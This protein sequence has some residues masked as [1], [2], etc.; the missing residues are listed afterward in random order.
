MEISSE[1]NI[2]QA[3]LDDFEQV[4]VLLQELIQDPLN[5]RKNFFQNALTSE[6]YVGLVAEKDGEIIGFL[7]IWHFP[8]PGHGAVL[9]IIPSFIVSKNYRKMGIGDRLL[10]EAVKIAK[11]RKFREFH[12]WTENEN[13]IAIDL[14]KKHGFTNESLVLERELD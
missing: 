6:T 1:I 10:E 3:R 9:G 13:K 12:V 8:D 7:D 2:R 14:Y 5:D 4:S 11:Q